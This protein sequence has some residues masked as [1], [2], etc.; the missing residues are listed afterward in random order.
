MSDFA[1]GL[2]VG[3]VLSQLS[4]GFIVLYVNSRTYK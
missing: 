2:L 1:V 4:V 3:F